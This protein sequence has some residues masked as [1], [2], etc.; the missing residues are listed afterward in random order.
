[1]IK[2]ILVPL[3]G[4]PLAERA[5]PVAARIARSSLGSIL[6]LRVVNTIGELGTY[7]IDPS[8]I[9]QETL[10]EDIATATDY[11]SAITRQDALE[12]V[13]TDIGIFTGTAPLQ[14]I[15][16]AHAQHIDLT[17]MSSHG[18]TGLK[19]WMMG[20]VAQ[21][22]IRHSPVPVLV[23][24][25]EGERSANL[26]REDDQPLRVLI[27]LDGSQLSESALEPAIQTAVKLASPRQCEIDLLRVVNVPS[28][29]GGWRS[30]NHIDG[31]MMEKARVAAVDYMEGVAQRLRAKVAGE[32]RVRI[33]TLVEVESDAA[34]TII[35]TAEN[36][37]EG[38]G[39]GYDLI[40]MAT[41]GRSGISRWALGSITERVL[42]ATHAP[43]M[44]V[45]PEQLHGQA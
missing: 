12:G 16:V 38:D 18:E 32:P 7:M 24:R 3:D 5:I 11:L 22:V 43:I 40:A 15:E 9:A 33:K 25:D 27:T 28:R 37:G 42:D 4:S 21:K 2:R 23:L 41:H 36:G 10:E 20:S 6:F 35:R 29:Y 30:H 14:I 39:I 13:E 31:R 26:T 34:E 17:V 44:V 45:R 19:R 8:V 1:M